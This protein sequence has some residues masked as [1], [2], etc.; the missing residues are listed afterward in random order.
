MSWS[1]SSSTGS[2]LDGHSFR[3]PLKAI[4]TRLLVLTCRN[5]RIMPP[6]RFA[7]DKILLFLGESLSILVAPALLRDISGESSLAARLRANAPLR[8]DGEELFGLFIFRT[9]TLQFPM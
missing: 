5:L 6:A 3:L 9:L 7:S 1:G 4:L 2:N 8:L